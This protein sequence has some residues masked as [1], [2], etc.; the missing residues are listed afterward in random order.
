MIVGYVAGKSP[1]HQAHPFTALALAATVVV[2]AF[3]LPAPQG[4]AA[5]AVALAAL[6][7]LARLPRVLLTALG[8]S[9]PFWFFLGV[10]HGLIGETPLRALTVGAQITAMLTAFLLVLAT[11]HP[12]RLVDALLQRGVPFSLAY[13]LSAT[14]QAVP[15]LRRQAADIVEAQR[16]RGLRVRG[17]VWRRT[18]AV[19]PLAIPLVLGALGE[20]DERA[21]ALDA[22]GAAAPAHRTALEP[23]PDSTAQRVVRW[24]LAAAAVG[25]IVWRVLA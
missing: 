10:I 24:L 19:V 21:M 9:L 23:P 11:V 5:L 17:S 14:L 2:L 4:P 8:F 16:C 15:R 12:A 6:A 3:A 20:V 13:L 7:L 1:L 25:V 22:R 18:R